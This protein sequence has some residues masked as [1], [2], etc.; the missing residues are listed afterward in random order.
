MG[1]VLLSNSRVE[2]IRR[3]GRGRV[4][5]EVMSQR[6]LAEGLTDERDFRNKDVGDCPLELSSGRRCRH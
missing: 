2:S 5:G 4:Q 1:V 6:V 3:K